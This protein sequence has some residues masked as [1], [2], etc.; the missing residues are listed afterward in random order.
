MS[1]YKGLYEASVVT[2]DKNGEP[3]F[4]YFDQGI[5]KNYIFDFLSKNLDRYATNYTLNVDF[6]KDDGI[7]ECSSSELAR[8][9]KLSLKANINFL[10]KYSKQQ[11][12]SIKDAKSLW[13]ISY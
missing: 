7:S 1:S 4:P 3:I 5:L 2:V 9:V 10:F 6:Y 8:N 12:F 13:M 11:S